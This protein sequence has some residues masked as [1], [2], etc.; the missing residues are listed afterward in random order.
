MNIIGPAFSV[1]GSNIAQ[2]GTYAKWACSVDG[3]NI[4]TEPVS[5]TDENNRY[6]C[7]K[8]GMD[9]GPHSLTL[10]AIVD[11]NQTFWFDRIQ[12]LPT[13]GFPVTNVTT[14]VW[15]SDSEPKY[16]SSWTYKENTCR[17]TT[18]YGSMAT[19]DFYGVYSERY[20]IGYLSRNFG[21]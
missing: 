10:R 2:N 8:Y 11:A 6:L 15:S 3:T 20:L 12:Y 1:M 18:Q 14:A 17:M 13:P 21:L 9:D 4:S 7:S 16:D 5:T 19:F